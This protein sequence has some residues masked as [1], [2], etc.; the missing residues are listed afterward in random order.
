MFIINKKDTVYTL[1]YQTEAS[2]TFR[3]KA[4]EIPMAVLGFLDDIFR[5]YMTRGF[6]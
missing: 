6:A 5:N 2:L 3:A 1:C 4:S